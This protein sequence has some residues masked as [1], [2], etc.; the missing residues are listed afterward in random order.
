MIKSVTLQVDGQI[1][2]QPVNCMGALKI[3]QNLHTVLPL[4]WG[5]KNQ[6]LNMWNES[7][8]LEHKL[9][10]LSKFEKPQGL[11]EPSSWGK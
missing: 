1:S 7:P 5:N 11:E 2:K 9:F 8:W 10:G 3:Y 4:A 6:V